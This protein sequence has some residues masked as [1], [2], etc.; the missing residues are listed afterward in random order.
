M[1]SNCAIACS[2]CCTVA[3]DNVGSDAFGIWMVR[4]P[5]SKP[6][7]KSLPWFW[8]ISASSVASWP[9]ARDAAMP[10]PASAAAP[11]RMARRL[12]WRWSGELVIAVPEAP[13]DPESSCRIG[14]LPE[15]KAPRPASSRPK[16]A[17][18]GKDGAGRI[19]DGMPRQSGPKMHQ[20]PGGGN[21]G[22]LIAAEDGGTCRGSGR[23]E[24]IEDLVGPKPLEPVQRLVQGRELIGGDAADLLHRAHVLLIETLDDV[25]D[26]TAGIGQTNAYRA[27]IDPRALVIEEAHLDELLQIVGDVGAQIVTPGTQLA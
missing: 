17:S 13:T 12:G 1:L 24:P 27:A 21:P 10:P 18:G 26:L 11:R 7:P 3:G 19:Y 6:W 25:A 9:N 5:E 14:F 2:V 16:S 15:A 4:E 22:G 20:T 23:S 8:S